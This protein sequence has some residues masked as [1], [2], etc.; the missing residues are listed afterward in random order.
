MLPF[1]PLASIFPM[2]GGLDF[3][4]LA[5]HIRANGLREPAI[6]HEA[7]ILDGRNRAKA[8]QKIGV[9]L[10]TVPRAASLDPRHFIISKNLQRRHLSECQRAMAAVTVAVMKRGRPNKIRNAADLTAREAA[11]RFG[12]GTRTIEQ[13]RYVSQHPTK[14]LIEAVER[15]AILVDVAYKLATMM[16]AAN[17]AK[18]ERA[19][20]SGETMVGT[21]YRR[22]RKQHG[23]HRAEIRFDGLAG[24]LVKSSDARPRPMTP[25][26]NARLMGPPENYVLPANVDEA[27]SLVGDGVAVP[28]VRY[29]AAHVLEPILDRA[30]QIRS[31]LM[32]QASACSPK[33]RNSGLSSAAD[34]DDEVKR[35]LRL[36]S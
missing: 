13:A 10:K 16:S 14:G 2:V 28:V 30:W 6:T 33:P 34:A 35:G 12:V 17:L 24:A 20:W 11:K 32:G 26:E 18:V 21:F 36:Q 8:C 25:R 7:K 23:G 1:H 5:E 31:V 9:Q 4:A 3:E 15:N 27:R 29:L 22:T 19:R